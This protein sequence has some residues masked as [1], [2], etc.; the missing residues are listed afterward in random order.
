MENEINVFT[1]FIQRLTEYPV[2]KTIAGIFIWLISNCYGDF[3]P[4][5]GAVVAIAV[6]DWITGL[7][8]AWVDPD[9]K[10]ESSKLKSGAVKLAI[11]GVLLSIGHLCSL[12]KIAAV[13]QSII[14]GY[15][16]IT[17]SLSVLENIQK[18]SV[19]HNLQIPLLENLMMILQGKLKEFG[20][21][22]NDKN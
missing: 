5:Y 6:I 13:A 10:I 7:Y 8:F 14:E 9:T 21:E 19:L 15:I 2:W 20:D 4:A 17:E 11:Y 22:K 16:I 3:R 18:I 12:V 1:H